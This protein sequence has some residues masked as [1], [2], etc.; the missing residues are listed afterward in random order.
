[1]QQL[2]II[3][4]DWIRLLYVMKNYLDLIVCDPLRAEAEGRG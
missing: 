4:N 1:M 2:S 3:N